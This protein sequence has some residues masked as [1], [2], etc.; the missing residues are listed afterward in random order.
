MIKSISILDLDNN[1]A[2]Q[3]LHIILEYI[4]PWYN[5]V[6]Q[7]RHVYVPIICLDSICLSHL[8]SA[9]PNIVFQDSLNILISSMMIIGDSYKVSFG[10]LPP[11]LRTSTR[12]KGET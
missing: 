3:L 10:Q 11:I 12:N 1:L 6:F 7:G 4:R 9:K 8:F 5:H 2:S